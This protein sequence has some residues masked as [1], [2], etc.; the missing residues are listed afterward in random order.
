MIGIIGGSGLEDPEFLEDRHEIV[1]DTKFG[2]PSSPLITGSI[3]GVE[4]AF[5][6]RHGKGHSLMPTVVPSRANIMALKEYGCRMVLATTAC[7]SLQEDIKPGDFVFLDQFI[8][9]TKKRDYTLYGK[10]R[11]C[12]IS[13]DEPFCSNM[14]QT[15]ISSAKT[16][17]I[18]YHQKGTVVT[19]EGPRFS[20]R[21]ESRMWRILG[22]DVINMSTVP[23]AQLAREAGMCYASIAMA[24]DYDCFMEGREVTIEEVLKTFKINVS[25]VKEL[26]SHSL[27]KFEDKPGCRCRTDYQKSFV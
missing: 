22:A 14:R 13:M 12:H 11:V 17:G 21:A 3:N 5:I 16:L 26:I 1:V 9:M 24:T 23:E 8:D 6:S 2:R 27:P 18:R 20:T 10:D 4:I 25:K 7:G 19:I 15:L